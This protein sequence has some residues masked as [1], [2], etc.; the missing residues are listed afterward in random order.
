M[1]RRASRRTFLKQGAFVAAAPLV[2]SS[3]AWAKPPSNT[4]NVGFVAAGGKAKTHIEMAKKANLNCLAF[5]DVDRNQWSNVLGHEPWKNA[6]GYTDW[7]A[8]FEKHAK[9][10]DVVFVATPDH[11]H[12]APTMTAISLGIHCYTEKPLTWSVREAQ[13]LAQAYE[14]NPKVVT[15]MGNQGHAGDGWRR[16]YEIVKAGAIGDIVEFHTWTNRPIWPQGGGRPPKDWESARPE[17][18][19]LGGLDRPGSDAS[20]RGVSRGRTYP[21]SSGSVATAF[22]I[23]TIGEDFVDFGSGR[24]ATWHAT[25]P[26]ASTRL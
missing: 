26:T 21:Q 10:L 14:K 2:I 17:K 19:G 4:L 11:S 12:F 24:L 18:P 13:L 8:M 20:L 1:L 15:Q 16:A 3:R 5:A 7:R 6:A 25:P 23:H 22:T 9:D